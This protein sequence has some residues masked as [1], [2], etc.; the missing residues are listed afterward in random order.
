M[1]DLAVDYR[2][3]KS[4]NNLAEIILIER[5]FFRLSFRFMFTFDRNG[6][7]LKSLGNVKYIIWEKINFFFYNKC[8]CTLFYKAEL[9]PTMEIV[10]KKCLL[11]VQQTIYGHFKRSSRSNWVKNGARKKGYK[12]HL[13]WEVY[14]IY[15]HN[16]KLLQLFENINAIFSR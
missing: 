10:E 15:L 5:D 14:F 2:C 7:G 3:R 4:F 9:S 6:L 8:L 12:F 1:Y 13:N 16:E 11:S